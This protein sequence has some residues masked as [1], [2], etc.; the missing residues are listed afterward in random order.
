[1]LISLI[2]ASCPIQKNDI[3]APFGPIAPL[4]PELLADAPTD[5]QAYRD[6]GIIYAK[7]ALRGGARQAACTEASVQAYTH[8]L[9]AG[10]DLRDLGQLIDII[11]DPGR[12]VVGGVK[13]NDLF[14]GILN[15]RN[16]GFEAIDDLLEQ[17]NLAAAERGLQ[18]KSKSID[19]LDTLYHA[20]IFAEVARHDDAQ[21]SDCDRLAANAYVRYLA[22]STAT[23][24]EWRDEVRDFLTDESDEIPPHQTYALRYALA[25]SGE[26][27]VVPG[28]VED[29]A[30]YWS[31]AGRSNVRATARTPSRAASARSRTPAGTR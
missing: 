8:L 15:R 16:D 27:S 20:R 11:D 31:K 14:S 18:R 21:H 9:Y 5:P 12:C 4:V 10:P 19:P 6:L 1:M 29:V 13:G 30:E 25:L 7:I 3:V 26:A 2:L 23:P 17:G 28:L 22:G 24:A